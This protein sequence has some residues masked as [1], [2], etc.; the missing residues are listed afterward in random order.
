MKEGEDFLLKKGT[1]KDSQGIA[2]YQNKPFRGPHN[3][4]RGSY[5]KRPYG[6]I[7]HKAVTNRF[8]QEGGN[9]IFRGSSTPQ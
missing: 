3:K 7:P 9:R 1:S 8:P 6:A 2:P 5:R 4:K